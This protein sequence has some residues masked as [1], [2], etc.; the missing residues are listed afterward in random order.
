M[1]ELIE[2]IAENAIRPTSRNPVWSEEF[3]SGIAPD[4]GTWSYD[5]GNCGWGNQELQSYTRDADNVRVEGSQLIITA[6]KKGHEITSGRIKTENKFTF[7]YG[8]VEARIQVPDMGNG[9][10]PALWALGTG[11]PCV[12]WP[13]CGE[14]IL[15]EMG[16]GDA[17]ED[18]V[19]NRRVMSAAHWEKNQQHETYGITFDHPYNLD[20][21]FHLFRMEWTPTEIK[22][23]VDDLPIWSMNISAIAQF[24]EPHFLLLNLAVGG[25]QTGILDSA[26]ITA[27]FPA[28]Y[29]VDFIRIFDNGFTVLDGPASKR[30]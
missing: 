13:A 23:Y 18:K 11:F 8:T 27:P 28:E 6:M 19:A 10:W 1:Y 30:N 29:R 3:D 25:E 14:L 22:T 21:S 12:G 15:M 26:G 7:K 20:G 24:H 5:L 2:E 9:L 17:V 4:E 16:V